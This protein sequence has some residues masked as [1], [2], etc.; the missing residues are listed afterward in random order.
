MKSLSSQIQRAWELRLNQNVEECRELT[1]SLK[2]EMGIPL[3]QLTHE[4]I[5]SLFSKADSDSLVEVLLLGASLARAQKDLAYSSL[6]LEAVNQALRLKERSAHYR[7]YFEKGLNSL[8]YGRYSVALEE[9]QIASSL[10]R[11]QMETICALVNLLI[12]RDSLG[13]SGS[14]NR[15]QLNKAMKNFPQ[16]KKLS[17]VYSQLMLLDLFKDFR[18]GKIRSALTRGAQKNSKDFSQVESFTWWLRALPYHADYKELTATQWEKIPMQIP[19]S[20]HGSFRCRT[21]HGVLHPDDRKW[22]KPSE[23]VDRLYLWVWRW[24]AD[25]EKYPIQRVMALLKDT[26]VF[27]DPHRLT[28]E[29]CEL[30]KNAL[31]WLGL[32]DASSERKLHVLVEKLNIHVP[33]FF[34]LL[35]LEKLVIYYLTA[36]REGD[37]IL[38]ADYLSALKKHSLWSDSRLRFRALL[39]AVTEEKEIVP[40]LQTL[41]R[42]LQKLVRPK[43]RSQ[44]SRLTV[45]LTKHQ[46][47]DSKSRSKIVSEPMALALSLLQERGTVSCEQFAEVCFNLT[48]YDST[49]H[50]AKIFNLLARLRQLPLGDLHFRL[51]AGFIIA[52]G[53]WSSV[54]FIRDCA[55]AHALR[56][57][58]EWKELVSPPKSS[59]APAALRPRQKPKLEELDWKFPVTRRELEERAQL[60]RS[61]MTRLLTQWLND[62]SVVKVG[63]ARSTT[64]RLSPE[65][66]NRLMQRRSVS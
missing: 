15:L 10:A 3:G 16:P 36:R 14:H 66:G 33:V 46:V 62:G 21:L 54:T 41:A 28:A 49:I 44:D 23:F 29:D 19:L 45:D 43:D 34:P 20:V 8:L 56:S 12:C 4:E 53:D 38:S 39:E 55:L 35:E 9:F 5:Q 40:S 61:T 59:D 37:V 42:N 48:R 26:A 60:S 27:D 18:E 51:K 57:Q 58:P 30:L 32:F 47:I 52:E 2:Q 6:I 1:I 63:N 65:L 7:L 11:N 25:P 31:L 50:Q 17:G 22:T 64:Y 13:L 24:L